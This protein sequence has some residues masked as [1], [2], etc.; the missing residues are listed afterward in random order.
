LT[1]STTRPLEDIRFINSMKKY[2]RPVALFVVLTATIQ[3]GWS[4]ASPS[5]SDPFDGII[6]RW[7]KYIDAGDSKGFASLL[8]SDFQ[9]IAFGKRFTGEETIAMSKDYSDVR[10]QFSQVRHRGEGSVGYITFDIILNCKLKGEVIEGRAMEAYLLRKEGN[11]WKVA[12]KVIV[13][14]GQ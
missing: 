9:L 1:S 11:E 2:L 7:Y 10:T 8:T 12:T 14:Q 5:T 4:Q 6:D 13:M 3:L